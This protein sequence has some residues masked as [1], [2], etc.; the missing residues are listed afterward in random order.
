[1]VGS[2]GALYGIRSTQEIGYE[3]AEESTLFRLDTAGNFTTFYQMTTAQGFLKHLMLG[4]NG[5]LW[6][7]S[8]YSPNGQYGSVIGLDN[9]G[10]V[11]VTHSFDWTAGA[12]PEGS[13]TVGADG[14]IYGVTEHGGTSTTGTVYRIDSAGTFTSLHS[15]PISSAN[16]QQGLVLAKD[17]AL[18]G[19]AGAAPF[20]VDSAGTV[21]YPTI[22]VETVS[23]LVQGSDCALYGAAIVNDYTAAVYTAAVYRLFEPGH[24][25]Q[26][27]EFAALRD[28]V[29][30]APPFTVSATASSGLPVSFSASGR[31][32]LSGDQVLLKRGVGVCRVTASQAGDSRFEAAAPVTQEFRVRPPRSTRRLR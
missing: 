2:D 7:T 9:T 21:S 30:G 8:D 18:Y 20:R 5:L 4:N 26:T 32:R 12:S 22:P 13:L 14:A 17:G 28:R 29:V 23:P 10:A 19:L 1:V 15:F 6:A 16:P 24:L 25:C 11:A 31:C 3:Y 27:I